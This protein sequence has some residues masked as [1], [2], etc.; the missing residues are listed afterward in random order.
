LKLRSEV[1]P[2]RRRPSYPI[3]VAAALLTSIYGGSKKREVLRVPAIVRW[4]TGNECEAASMHGKHRFGVILLLAFLLSTSLRDIY[5]SGVFGQ[6]GFFEVAFAAFGTATACFL[7]LVLICA[8]A[9]L[10]TLRLAWREV[11]VVNATTAIAWLCYFGSLRLVEPSVTNTVYSGVAPLAV[12]VFA[13]C[14][15]KARAHVVIGR[16]ESAAHL[17]LVVALGTLAW[18]VLSGH[19]GVAGLSVRNG[20]AGLAL[21]AVSGISITAETVVAKRMNEAGVVP[22]AVLGVRFVFVTLIAAGAVCLGGKTTLHAPP[23]ALA[24]FVPAALLLIAVPIYLVQAGLAYTSPMITGVVLS[25]GPVF[26]FA[27][28]ALAG[29][30]PASRHV[31]AAIVLYAGFALLGNICLA[32]RTGS[33]GRGLATGSAAPDAL[34]LRTRS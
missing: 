28:Q 1:C 19:S 5:L 24:A 11:L 4:R 8:P 10:R 15:L 3:L 34:A 13:A 33:A 25:L 9:Q 2:R 6:F 30:T 12:T 23:T 29:T 32:R 26:V 27:A 18:V 20:T 7:G 14:G 21:A 22:A 16:A 31:L 17:G